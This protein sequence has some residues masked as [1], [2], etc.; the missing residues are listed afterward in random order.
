MKELARRAGV[1]NHFFRSWEFAFSEKS[2]I[3][4]ICKSPA[5][6]IR[7]RNCGDA[8]LSDL[9][10]GRFRVAHAKWNDAPGEPTG[11]MTPDFVVPFADEA[12]REGQ[13]LFRILDS[14]TA[15]C[16]FDLP[17]SLL[18][19]LSRFE[20]T[21]PVTRDQYGRFPA[22]ESLASKEGFLGRPIVDEYGLAFEQALRNLLPGWEPEPRIFRAMVTHDIDS[23]GIPFS[24]RQS[25]GHILKRRNPMAAARD[26]VAAVTRLSPAYLEA[27]RDVSSLAMGA[28]LTPAVYWK[29]SPR[30]PMDSGYD[31]GHP[32]VRKMIRW[33]AEHGAENGIHPGFETYLHPERL[34]E[35]A[36]TLREIFETDRIGGRQHYLRWSPETWLDWESC[37]LAYD[38]SVGF[39]DRIGFRAGTC[40]PYRPWMLSENRELR[41]VE[42]PL[43]VME[44]T[45]THYMGLT[46]TES[47]EAI[48]GCIERCRTVGGVFTLLWHNTSLIEPIYGDIFQ[49]ALEHLSGAARFDWEAA[50]EEAQ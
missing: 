34:R 44:G 33:V 8:L 45:L 37:G 3:V 21:L 13:P 12:A 29:A 46:R 18:L 41:L 20:E 23:V 43:L 10:V 32:K 28:G 4:T 22:S 11:G 2:T 6:K 40:I 15:E 42:I 36:A 31:P 50:L 35:E 14:E 9:A 1:T 17:L 16:D 26:V 25:L 5:K 49:K 24:L 48:K 19:T 38:S 47:P 39:A 27:V 7:F 30:G